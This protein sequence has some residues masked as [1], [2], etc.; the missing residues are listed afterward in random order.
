MD[1]FDITDMHDKLVTTKKNEVEQ[2]KKAN[3]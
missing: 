3:R 1:V 2:A